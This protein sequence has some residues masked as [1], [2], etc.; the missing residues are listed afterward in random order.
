MKRNFLFLFAMVTIIASSSA[1][2]SRRLMFRI[3]RNNVSAATHKLSSHLNKNGHVLFRHASKSTSDCQPMLFSSSSFEMTANEIQM[4][5]DALKMINASIR[6]VDPYA[7]IKRKMVMCKEGDTLE[8]L[9]VEVDDDDGAEQIKYDMSNYDR[10]RVI[11]FGKASA[12]MA[13]AAG[14]IISSSGKQLDGVAIIKDDHA[15]AEEIELLKEKYN[16]VVRPA[17]HPVPDAR[18]VAGSNEILQLA[19]TS[20]SRT[21]VIACISGGGSALFCSP[22]EPLTL[23]DLMQTNSA[24][25]ASGMPIE[26]M[27][28]IRKRLE[29]GKGGKLAAAAFPATVLTLVLSDI[30]GDP[31][32]LIASGPTVP[33]DGSGWDDACRLVQEYGLEADGEYALP[34][35]VLNLLRLGKEGQLEDTP[36]SSHPA[37][38]DSPPLCQT[39]LVGNNRA[40]VMAAA[41]QAGQLGYNPVVLGTRIDGEA[42]VVAGTYVA[43]AEMISQ[44][45]EHHGVC[46]YQIAGLPAALIAG[47]ET[48][49]TIPAE[50]N[51]KGGRNQEL[52]LSAAIKLKEIGLRDVVIASCGSDGTDGPTDAAGAIV[53]GASVDRI[54]QTNTGRCAHDAM[55]NHDAYHFFH[56]DNADYRSHHLIQT[57]PTG[58]NVADV[59]ITLIK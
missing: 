56:D 23:D 9:V 39:V 27:N 34:D 7:A 25:L 52:A 31:I 4:K 40:A 14:E 32:D 3:S 19:K 48:V 1:F 22:R 15:T 57:G 37:F 43:M 36:K 38:C 20:D 16:I 42:S 26:K 12:P 41:N 54:E 13:L 45:R 11:S 18:S 49:V 6:A 24:L 33:D 17:A 5:D 29:N 30:I 51:G 46:S 10:I 44:Q 35:T 21:L 28:V 50:C 58:T 53:D 59:M 47:G 55:K 2:T 8:T